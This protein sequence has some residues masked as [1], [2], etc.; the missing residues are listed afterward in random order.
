MPAEAVAVHIEHRKAF[1]MDA[2][3]RPLPPLPADRA[4]GDIVR[5]GVDD[6]L[7]DMGMA[8]KHRLDVVALE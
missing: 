1:R 7:H 3:A 6:L 5:T 2:Q 8:L 4:A